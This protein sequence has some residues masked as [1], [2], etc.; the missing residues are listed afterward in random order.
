MIR[1]GDWA[2]IHSTVTEVKQLIRAMGLEE[3]ASA[4]R[5][6]RRMWNK[7]RIAI[8]VMRRG[9][10]KRRTLLQEDLQVLRKRG[11]KVFGKNLQLFHRHH[12][13]GSPRGFGLHEYE[14]SCS[15]SPANPPKKR[16]ITAQHY[17]PCIQ[18][19]A[20]ESPVFAAGSWLDQMNTI[21]SPEGVSSMETYQ[22]AQGEDLSTSTLAEGAGAGQVDRKAEEFI[23]R[24]YKQ[25]EFQRQVSLLEYQEMLARGAN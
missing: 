8:F 5:K 25:I 20:D 2:L 12:V 14:F 7:L 23:E 19:Q 24:F 18:P 9:L 15:N 10:L 4:L 1:L 6:K 16:L 13:T 17:F 22:L 21:E 11:Y 3:G